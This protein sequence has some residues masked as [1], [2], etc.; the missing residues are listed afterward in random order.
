MRCEQRRWLLRMFGM[1][2]GVAAGDIAS[3]SKSTAR[4]LF[5]VG[6]RACVGAT[7][8][9]PEKESACV[10]SATVCALAELLG[11]HRT[12]GVV[13]SEVPDG[14]EHRRNAL[15]QLVPARDSNHALVITV[16]DINLGWRHRVA[17]LWHETC[18]K[19]G[20]AERAE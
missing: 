6:M 9:T 4:E 19:R 11:T 20:M 2:A 12:V 13:G 14:T 18:S 17:Q 5:S 3:E 7:R 1:S 15:M 10:R 16:V 8:R